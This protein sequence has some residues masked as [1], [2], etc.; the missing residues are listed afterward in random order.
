MRTRAAH[1][2]ANGL[3][4]ACE[5]DCNGNGVPDLR[6]IALGHSTD[7][8][9][10]GIPDECETDCNGNCV[11]TSSDIQNCGGCGIACGAGETCL[12]SMCVPCRSPV[13]SESRM[14]ALS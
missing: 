2:R 8:H 14:A 3:P 11:D 9:L 4:D 5:A 10:N 6:D 7:L 12:A 1:D 13:E